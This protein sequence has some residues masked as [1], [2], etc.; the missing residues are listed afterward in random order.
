MKSFPLIEKRPRLGTL[1]E[2]PA[3]WAEYLH[4]RNERRRF[5]PHH[6]PGLRLWLDSSDWLTLYQDTGMTTPI[7]ADG[8][9]IGAVSDKSGSGNHALQAV[10]GKR[11]LAKVAV[12]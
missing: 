9:P 3:A 1:K 5:F 2:A 7:T 11:P 4:D 8:Q 10:A 6:V 12:A